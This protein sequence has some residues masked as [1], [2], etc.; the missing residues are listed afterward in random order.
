MLRIVIGLVRGIVIGIVI[1]KV[2]GMVIGKVIGIVMGIVMAI[3][4]GKIIG[5]VIGRVFGIISL[6][7]LGGSGPNCAQAAF[8]LRDWKS[9]AKPVGKQLLLGDCRL[10]GPRLR[11]QSI[12]SLLTHHLGMLVPLLVTPVPPITQLIAIHGDLEP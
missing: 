5:T 6:T 4:I 2:M 7:L 11:M 10:T 3:V 8:S 9:K 1:G 12:W